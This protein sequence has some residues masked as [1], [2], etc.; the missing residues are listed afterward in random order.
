MVII[1]GISGEMKIS[2]VK[3]QRHILKRIEVQKQNCR[4]TANHNQEWR[5]QY[6]GG[7]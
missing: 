6:E 3:K 1:K 7:K 5:M 2:S 4:Q